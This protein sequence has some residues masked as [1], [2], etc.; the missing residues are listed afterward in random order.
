MDCRL[1]IISQRNPQT[2]TV[3]NRL[4]YQITL[5]ALQGLFTFL[6]TNHH[7]ASVV[8]EV[9]DPGLTGSMVRIGVI[10]I[11]PLEGSV[12]VL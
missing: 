3:P 7:A 11:N 9:L 8:S 2:R 1:K 5:N 12:N 4:T 10:S 6:Y